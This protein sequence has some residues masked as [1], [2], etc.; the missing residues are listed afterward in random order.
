MADRWKSQVYDEQR[1]QEALRKL[2]WHKR[3]D[4]LT[5]VCASTYI[6]LIS[7][8]ISYLKGWLP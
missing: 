4:W 3:Y 2:R 1:E 7:L 8:A 6:I 5:I